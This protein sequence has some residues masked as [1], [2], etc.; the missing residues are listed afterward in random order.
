MCTIIHA[1]F[2]AAGRAEF[3]WR[4]RQLW[5]EVLRRRAIE[6]VVVRGGARALR[7][8]GRTAA[9]PLRDLLN[10]A[11]PAA[12]RRATEEEGNVAPADIE[13]TLERAASGMSGLGTRGRGGG[14]GDWD[15]T[16]TDEAEV[17]GKSAG[18]DTV[19]TASTGTE[20][21]PVAPLLRVAAVSET[22]GGAFAGACALNAD[23]TLPVTAVKSRPSTRILRNVAGSSVIRGGGIAENS[24]GG[25]RRTAVAPARVALT[26]PVAGA[27]SMGDPV[28]LSSAAPAPAQVIGPIAGLPRIERI[29]SKRKDALLPGREPPPADFSRVRNIAG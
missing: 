1:A 21:P 27:I 26:G 9:Q 20:P 17:G 22:R 11:L 6:A 28:D 29:S 10:A 2:A 19:P 12:T 7:S 8:V 13:V 5:T 16:Q 18:L 3:E 23:A 4:Y 25:T 15:L 24:S 14:R